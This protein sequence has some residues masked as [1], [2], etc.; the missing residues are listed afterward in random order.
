M[1]FLLQGLPENEAWKRKTPPPMRRDLEAIIKMSD[2]DQRR[3][4]DNNRSVRYAAQDFV[5]GNKLDALKAVE[6]ARKE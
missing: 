1:E 2:N 3:F 5:K 6:A 4:F